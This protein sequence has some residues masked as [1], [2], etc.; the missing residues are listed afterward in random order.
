M[1]ADRR[2]QDL[3]GIDLPII[4]APM[5]GSVGSE[6]V[7]AVSEAGGLGSLPCAMLSPEQMQ[8]EP[9][10]FG[11]APRDRS[12]STSSVTTRHRPI[13]PVRRLGSGAWRATTLSSGSILGRLL[14]R[15]P[16]PRLTAPCATWWR[17]SRRRWSASISACLSK[18]F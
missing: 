16:V 12:A 4:Q 18:T 2:I 14:P 1:W 10:S 6:M 15:R 7:I 17:S 13:Q 11:N 3:F 5:A 8:T 9:G